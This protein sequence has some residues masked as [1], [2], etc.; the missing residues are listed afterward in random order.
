MLA[1]YSTAR[2]LLIGYD[3]IGAQIKSDGSSSFRAHR[4]LMHGTIVR[5]P[6]LRTLTVC[7]V[8]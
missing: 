1:R 6:F 4:E 3:K 2:V 8:V 5:F 7:L